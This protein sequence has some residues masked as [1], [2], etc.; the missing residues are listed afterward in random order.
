[1]DSK[2]EDEEKRNKKRKKEECI[3]PGYEISGEIVELGEKVSGLKIGDKVGALN[4]D[5]FGGLATHIT[6]D[7]QVNT[8]I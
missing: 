3:T 6:A 2:E 4:I 5:A 8:K 7:T 1:M